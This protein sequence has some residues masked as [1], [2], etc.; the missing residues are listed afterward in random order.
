MATSQIVRLANPPDGVRPPPLAPPGVRSL[1]ESMYTWRPSISAPFISTAAAAA[2]ESEKLT[3]A[4]PRGRPSSP[5]AALGRRD[6][7]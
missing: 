3:C 6:T 1:A 2:E 4:N 5:Y 7:Y